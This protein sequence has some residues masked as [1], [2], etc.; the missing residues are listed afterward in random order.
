MDQYISSLAMTRTHTSISITGE[1]PSPLDK[2]AALIL[3][4]SHWVALNRAEN[5]RVRELRLGCDHAVGD[6]VVDGLYQWSVCSIYTD[7]ALLII[8]CALP[9]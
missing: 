6:V 8:R 2:R 4:A 5:A 9:A 3:A 1:I 7:M